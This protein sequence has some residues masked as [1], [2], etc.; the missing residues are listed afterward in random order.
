[1]PILTHD[2]AALR[3]DRVGSGPAVLFIH[4]LTGNRTYWQK[5]VAALRDRFTVVTIDLRGHGESSKPKT[6][7][8]IGTMAA[9]LAALVRTIGVPRVAIVGWSMG[10]LV[11][12]ELARRLE[13]R[14]SAL[15]LV[16]TSAGG[17]PAS[18]E[19]AE[20][21][22]ALRDAAGRDFRA[23][24]RTFAPLAFKAGAESPLH[25]WHLAEIGKMAPNAALAAA[26]ALFAFD[27]RANLA[28]LSVPTLVIHGR[29]DALMPL[30][31]GEALA[32]AIPGAT[33]RIFEESGHSPHLEEPDAFNA[34]V[35]EFLGRTAQ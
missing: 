9:D 34:A 27:G 31:G 10:G 16:G 22:Q 2:G 28:G 1:M 29:H 15:V 24:A 23:F 33:L 12:Q 21:R 19:E 26:D 17:P 14:A 8:G 18:E 3:Y 6:G 25:A 13:A 11:G 4:G 35:G 20:R 7:Y 32:A 30:A 5:Q